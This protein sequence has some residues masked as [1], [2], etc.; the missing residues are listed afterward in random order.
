MKFLRPHIIF[1]LLFLL[2]GICSTNQLYAQDSS[3]R[4][5]YYLREVPDSIVASLQKDKQFTYA[6]DAAYWA[7]KQERPVPLNGFLDFIRRPW[8]RNLVYLVI[9]VLVILAIYTVLKANNMFIFYASARKKRTLDLPAEATLDWD[10]SIAE[11]LRD[12]DFRLAIRY[13]FLQLL[14]RLHDKNLITWH[15]ET[16][17]AEYLLALRKHPRYSEFQSLT[18]IYEYAW[19]GDFEVSE[20]MYRQ[21]AGRF[22]LLNNRI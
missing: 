15:P 18:R 2:K 1:V 3:G 7:I 16:T 22:N 6:N 21:V 11:A 4:Q 13:H 14:H 9:G 17:N 12:H 5:N 20:S 8:F 10:M 19:Y